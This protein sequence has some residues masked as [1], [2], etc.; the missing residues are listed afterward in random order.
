[1]L[2]N[3]LKNVMSSQTQVSKQTIAKFGNPW[4]KCDGK[5]SSKFKFGQT[6]VSLISWFEYEKNI[7]LRNMTANVQLYAIA[8]PN[9]SHPKLVTKNIKK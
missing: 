7:K 6:W 5:S 4:T 2:K 8:T 9:N 1:M 3:P